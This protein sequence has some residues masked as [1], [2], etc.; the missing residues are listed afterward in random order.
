VSYFDQL[1]LTLITIDFNCKLNADDDYDDYDGDVGRA[2]L[3]HR[4]IA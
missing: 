2:L 1:Q 3:L 4:C